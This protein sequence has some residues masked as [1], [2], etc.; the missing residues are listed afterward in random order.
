MP[1]GYLLEAGTAE[2]LSDVTLP[3][4]GAATSFTIDAPPARYWG[5]VRAINAAGASAPSS[6]LILDVDVTES[7]CYASP[8]LAPLNLTA[9]VLGRRVS[10][11]WAQHPSGPVANTQR[12]V[13]GTAPGLDDLGTTAVPGPAT[14]FSTT[15]PPG[16]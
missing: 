7:P 15:A 8:P 3:L 1:A 9:S 6:E 5:R 16:T 4:N 13:A 14:S 2:G 11:S 10:L 12:V